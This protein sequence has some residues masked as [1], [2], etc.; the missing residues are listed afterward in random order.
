[1]FHL[2]KKSRE[3]NTAAII[4]A[5]GSSS[6]MGE[7]KMFLLLDGMPVVAKSIQAFGETPEINQIVVVCKEG[8]IGEMKT[9]L[10]LYEFHKVSHI[11]AGGKTRQESVEKGLSCVMEDT[12][13]IAIHDGARPL[14][15]PDV[16]S[17]VIED[18]ETYGAATACVAAKDTVKICDQEGFVKYTP[19]REQVYLIQT[20]QVFQKD[21]YKNAL[22]KAKET[23][24]EYTDDC[25][26]LEHI[27]KK[28]FLSMGSYDNIKLTTPDDYITARALLDSEGE[29]F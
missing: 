15:T 26:L 18:A 8:D 16:I 9:I 29:Y 6:R 28:V 14:I 1:M 7:N 23:G 2:F 17:C 27:D 11:V 22:S 5:A 12:K 10:D 24:K 3:G 19:P 4:V 20:P 21:E 13:Y 25:Q